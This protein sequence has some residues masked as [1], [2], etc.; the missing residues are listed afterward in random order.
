MNTRAISPI[1]LPVLTTPLPR[2]LESGELPP[3]PFLHA[4][5]RQS[6]H[7][8]LLAAPQERDILSAAEQEQL[9]ACEAVIARGWDTFLE[10]GRS[11]ARIRDGRLYRQHYGT[12]EVYCRAKWQYGRHYANHL[13]AAAETVEHLVTKVTILPKCKTQVRPLA[14]LRPEQALKGWQKAIE[15]AR[16]GEVTAKHV[17][18]AVAE[19]KPSPGSSKKRKKGKETPN[20][21]LKEQI[22]KLAASAKLFLEDI[23]NEEAVMENSMSILN[24]LTEIEDHA[25]KI[26]E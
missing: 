11:L 14:G 16:G 9:S 3:L 20:A 8:P 24:L 1:P 12:F 2:L 18:A 4:G 6:P 21:A 5:L 10:V 25:L 15:L 23:K 26:R 22:R 13:I 7:G 19:F 17:Q